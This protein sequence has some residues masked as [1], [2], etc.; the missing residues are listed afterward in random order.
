M[1]SSDRYIPYYLESSRIF[2]NARKL[3]AKVKG[4]IMFRI[5]IDACENET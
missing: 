5:A 1:L 2:K 3:V 4:A